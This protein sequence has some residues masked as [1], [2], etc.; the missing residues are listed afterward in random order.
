MIN[1]KINI[2]SMKEEILCFEYHKK[3]KKQSISVSAIGAPRLYKK[4]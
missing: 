2:N 4:I 1:H 3:T